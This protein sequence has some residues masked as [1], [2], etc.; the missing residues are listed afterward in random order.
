MSAKAF[1]TAA[2]AL[3][4]ATLVSLSTAPP[5][6]AFGPV[7]PFGRHFDGPARTEPR[8]G[9]VAFLLRIFDFAGGAMDP[10]GHS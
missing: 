3:L 1:R 4:L 9:F 7:G 2:A 10:N 8:S 5:A 6:H